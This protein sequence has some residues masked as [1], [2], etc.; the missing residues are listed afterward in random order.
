MAHCQLAQGN[1]DPCQ[2]QASRR[3]TRK[4]ATT[5][6]ASQGLSI[7]TIMRAG[8]W[9][10]TF[11]MYGHYIRR[12]PKEVLFRILEQTSASIQGV[13]V[14]KIATDNPC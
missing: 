8:D 11:T 10:Y 14:A 6:I 9:A 1:L 13:N 7:R 2:Y 12:I 5:H 3:S 4:A